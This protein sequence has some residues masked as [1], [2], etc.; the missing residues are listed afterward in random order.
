MGWNSWVKGRPK[1]AHLP[2]LSCRMPLL[3]AAVLEQVLQLCL[4]RAQKTHSNYFSDHWLFS[5]RTVHQIKSACG[6]HSTPYDIWPSTVFLSYCVPHPHGAPEASPLLLLSSQP[7]SSFTASHS[8]LR[9]CHH[10]RSSLLCTSGLILCL[11][12]VILFLY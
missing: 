3:S 1:V 5:L 11:P 2:A 10:S 9:R 12:S 6:Q 8:L 7:C 4:K